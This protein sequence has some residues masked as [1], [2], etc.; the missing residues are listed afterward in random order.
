MNLPKLSI[1]DLRRVFQAAQPPP[2]LTVSQW[3]DAERRLSSEASAEEGAWDTA[4]AEYQRGIMDAI[5]DPEMSEVSVRTSAQVGKTEL[6]I[7]AVGYY[8]QHD[9]AP[10]L[11]IEPTLELAQAI[12]KDRIAPMF[13]D[14]PA[15][16]GLV[17][18]GNKEDT[19]LHKLFLGGHLTLAGANSPASLSSRP[20]RIT[21][22]DE[23]DRYPPSA[24]AEGDPVTLGK[25]RT[26]NYWNRKHVLTSTP[27]IKGFSR[28]DNAFEEGD[29]R[30]F[31][32]PCAQCGLE[33]TLQWKNVKW[34]AGNANTA[35]YYCDGC[36]GQWSEG[37]RHMAVKAGQWKASKP[38]KG[39]ASFHLNELYSPWSD[40]AMMA[41]EFLDA[42]HSRNP[43]RVKAWINTT[44][45][46]SYEMAGETVDSELVAERLEDWDGEP[47]G[48][49][50]RT[51]GI[52][53]QDDRAE[54]ELVGWGE[55]EESWSLRYDVIHGDPSTAG[56]WDDIR[57]WLKDNNPDAT[58]I[59]SGGH[60]T[61]KV[62]EF[63]R[64][65]KA[66]RVYA[67]KGYAGARPIWPKRAAGRGKHGGKVYALGVD[68]AKEIIRARLKLASIG[69]GY[70]HFPKGRPQHY[71][72]G[73]ASE[74]CVTRWSK[75]FPVREWQRRIEGGHNEPWDC[76]VY[77]YAVLTSLNIRDWAPY[78]RRKALPVA[79]VAKPEPL[80]EMPAAIIQQ[81]QQQQPPAARMR[82]GAGGWVMG[83]K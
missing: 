61:Q 13:R 14:S 4:R 57:R 62:Y 78:K 75:G 28:I 25:A 27:S 60:Y 76:R 26:K 44:L 58:A 46:E 48:V 16:R 64:K 30:Y 67:I 65:Y 18:K 7:N 50:L 2:E 3:A 42:K 55:G 69:P 39:K 66:W 83:W 34:D 63:A 29:Q 24:G 36:G 54:M 15:L 21:F 59:D 56:F 33:Q 10:M 32:V 47:A 43:E 72:D 45:G 70:C 5:S 68:S 53:I 52:D 20:V 22:F 31:Y 12:S 23:V 74:I 49:L 38:C 41:Q 81:R 77:A 9:P 8:A 40:L 51:A 17:R 79:T 19:I 1:A 71:F 37:E 82:R 35:H 80:P 11:F 73:L 6:L